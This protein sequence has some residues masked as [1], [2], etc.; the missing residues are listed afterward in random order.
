MSPCEL[1]QA[2]IEFYKG[3]FLKFLQIGINRE[4]EYGVIVTNKLIKST[5]NRLDQLIKNKKT[6]SNTSDIEKGICKVTGKRLLY[7]SNRSFS[8]K[9]TSKFQLKDL[10]PMQQH[11]VCNYID[12]GYNYP[13]NEHQYIDKIMT[14]YNSETMRAVLSHDN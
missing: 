10:Q 14:A 3:Q 11:N 7:N 4:T 12:Y 5:E 9:I 1:N 6:S 8:G 2:L 13:Y